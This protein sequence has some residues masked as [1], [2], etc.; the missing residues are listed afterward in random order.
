MGGH[1][2]ALYGWRDRRIVERALD[3][4][5]NTSTGPESPRATAT[6]PRPR[7]AERFDLELNIT[8]A[9]ASQKDDA[10]DVALKLVAVDRAGRNVPAARLLLEEVVVEF[11]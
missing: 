9:L 4:L 6:R 2:T 11:E 1:R 5:R 8:R 7:R 3:F 10:T